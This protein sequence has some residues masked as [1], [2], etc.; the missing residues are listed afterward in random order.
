MSE[1]SYIENV[2]KEFYVQN[3]D[4]WNIH[5]QDYKILSDFYEKV[6]LGEQLT[7]NQGNYMLRLMTKYLDQSTKHGYD[8]SLALENPVWKTSFRTLD[9]TKRAYCEKDAEGLIW[10][11]IKFPYSFKEVFDKEFER[12]SL[13]KS[14]WDPERKLRKLDLQKYNIIHLYEFIAS[15]GFDIDESFMDVVFQAEEY[16]NEQDNIIPSATVVDNKVVLRN[17]MPDAETFWNTTAT[18]NLEKDMFLAKSMGYSVNLPHAP[19]TTL[20]NIVTSKYTN[21]WFKD[22]SKFFDLYKT[23]D[24]TAGIVIDRN[25]TDIVAWLDNFVR[26]TDMHGISRSDIKVCFRES[27]SKISKLN[28]W[29]KDNY[30]GGAVKDGK[31]L[32]FQHRPPKWLFKD[33]VDVKLI[34]T[35][36]FTPMNE[37][38]TSAW[39]SAHPC[40]C[41]LGDI[42]PTRVRDNKIVEL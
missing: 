13:Y 32:I 26:N 15:N 16:W 34:A 7:Q 9:Y 17:A 25:T 5:S 41:Y 12:A 23:I 27:D 29:I 11:C 14:V 1:K 21:F 38:L 39:V 37:P 42:K 35:N 30:V 20:E 8:Y 4:R 31:I 22:I 24:G 3:V 40:V 6:L 2:F 19:S 10:A 18:G 36:S 28:Q 33:S